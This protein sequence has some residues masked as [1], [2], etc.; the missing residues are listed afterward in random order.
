MSTFLLMAAAGL[1]GYAIGRSHA[2]FRIARR[3]MGATKKKGL[4]K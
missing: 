3:L 2:W 1:A 4:R